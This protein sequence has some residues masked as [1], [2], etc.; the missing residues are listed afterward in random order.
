LPMDL[1]Q[2]CVDRELKLI[3]KGEP[4]KVYVIGIDLAK[5]QDETVVIILG[6]DKEEFTLRHIDAWSKMDYTEQVARIGELGEKFRIVGGAVDQTGVGEAIIEDLKAE[7]RAVEGVKFTQKTKLELAS[8]LR[9]SMEHEILVMPDDQK[10]IAQL[11]SLHYR[12]GNT[13]ELVFESSASHDDYLWA[14][15]LAVYAARKAQASTQRPIVRSLNFRH[16]E[17]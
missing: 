15:A 16:H 14:L 6:R 8:G 10:L 12:I 17:Y 2:R 13:G 5:Q 9:W 1:I 4:Q 11:N 7:I 3:N